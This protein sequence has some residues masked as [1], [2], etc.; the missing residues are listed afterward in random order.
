MFILVISTVCSICGQRST[1]EEWSQEG[2]RLIPLMPRI[3]PQTAYSAIADEVADSTNK[4]NK[5]LPLP[6]STER[7]R[8]I[9]VS[10][11]SAIDLGGKPLFRVPEPP[12]IDEIKKKKFSL[13]VENSSL[14]QHLMGPPKISRIQQIYRFVFFKRVIFC[15]F[16]W[17][18]M[19]QAKNEGATKRI[20]VE[21]EKRN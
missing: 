15:L 8:S 12:K 19:F 21:I 7:K 2:R 1:S 17:H 9:P 6:S 20:S 5:Q 11:Q 16:N 3:A 14:A 4:S 13:G 18:Y 10:A